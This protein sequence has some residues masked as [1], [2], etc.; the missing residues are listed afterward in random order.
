[1][2]YL[3]LLSFLGAIM[4]GIAVL[5]APAWGTT[6]PDVNS[7][8]NEIDQLKEQLGGVLGRLDQ[9]E[10]S[11]KYFIW[12]EIDPVWLRE[13]LQGPRGE[14]GPAGPKGDQGLPGSN[15]NVTRLEKEL[16]RVKQ[17]VKIIVD[18]K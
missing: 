14:M 15:E 6:Q 11:F 17:T 3:G 1:M 8:E 4:V 12:K 13:N 10:T 18:G 5:P 2:G 7:G 16:Q 9:L